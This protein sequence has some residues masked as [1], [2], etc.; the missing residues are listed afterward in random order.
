MV[1]EVFGAGR[2]SCGMIENTTQNDQYAA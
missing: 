2:G 1:E